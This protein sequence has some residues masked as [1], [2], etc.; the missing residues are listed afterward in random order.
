MIW[1]F[2]VIFVLFMQAGLAGIWTGGLQSGTSVYS[3]LGH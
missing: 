2:D 1:E 3:G